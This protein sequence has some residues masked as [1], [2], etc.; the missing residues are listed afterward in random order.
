MNRLM[1]ALIAAGCAIFWGCA[2][3]VLLP[4]WALSM[5]AQAGMGAVDRARGI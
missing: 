4:F 5:I 1:D 2:L 3:L